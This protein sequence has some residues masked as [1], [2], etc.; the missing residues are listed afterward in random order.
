MKP[1]EISAIMSVP[2]IQVTKWKS[3]QNWI[4]NQTEVQKIEALTPALLRDVF[5][6]RGLSIEDVI[7]EIVI[8]IK[9]TTMDGPTSKAKLAYIEK[10]FQ[11]IGMA[12]NSGVP[13]LAVGEGGVV[14]FNIVQGGVELPALKEVV[15][16]KEKNGA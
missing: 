5:A 6:Q 11:I 16:V 14:N 13:K 8:E 4:H 3:Q 1:S 2:A 12:E 9:K 7:Q 15:I 10:Y